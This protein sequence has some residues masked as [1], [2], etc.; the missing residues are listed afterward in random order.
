MT[1]EANLPQH[2]IERLWPQVTANPE[3][4]LHQLDL[5]QQ[6]GL[7]IQMPAGAY[8]AA[9]FLDGRSFNHQTLGGWIPFQQIQQTVLNGPI[10]SGPLH[11][12]FHM[13][14]TGSTLI[15]RL[16]DETGVVQSLREPL[17]LRDLAVMHDRRADQAHL[18]SPTSVDDWTEIM[19]RL[20]ARHRADRQCAIVKATSSTARIG[21]TLM[22]NRPASR[23]VY[24]S[25]AA[26]PYLAVI[27][28]GANSLVDIRGHAEERMRRLASMLGESPQ[29]LYELSAGEQI[30]ASWVCEALT[31]EDIRQSAGD[32]LM[33][34]DFDDFLANVPGRVKKLCDHF[35]LPS[36]DAVVARIAG[37]P[38]LGQYAKAPEH[39]YSSSLRA[40]V[41]QDSRKRNRSEIELGLKWIRKMAD[42]YPAVLALQNL[43]A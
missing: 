9:S 12:I 37:S 38:T 21:R 26:E 28:G 39:A 6:N 8:R 40:D 43:N 25:M 14:H 19:L 13:G 22:E 7:F 27:L 24:L 35:G 20:W 15:S 16:L 41:I 3:L 29:P 31:R 10:L 30:A 34:L 42:Q 18:I 32:R 17:V 36:S 4:H 2:A 23:A 33:R 11:F 1:T 5:I